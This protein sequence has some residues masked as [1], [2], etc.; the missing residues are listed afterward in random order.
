[1]RLQ[2]RINSHHR[3][4]RST[5]IAL[6]SGL[7]QRRKPS[8]ALQDQETRIGSTATVTVERVN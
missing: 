6:T 4:S 5:A 2:A 8:F 7:K 1:L 3:C